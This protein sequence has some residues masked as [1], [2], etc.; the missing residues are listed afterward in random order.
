MKL[1]GKIYRLIYINYILAKNGLDE[2]ILAMRWFA[3]I[4]FLSYL[5]PWYWLRNRKKSRAERLR[6]TLESLGPIFVKFGQ[7]LSTRR[8]LLPEDI[9]NE[10][11]KLQ[12]KVPPFSG[13]KKIIE[14]TLEKPI[15]TL[16]VNFDEHALASASIAQ[17]HTAQLLDGQDV[18]IKVKRP[19]IEKIIKRDIDLL[20]SFAR[21][22]QH[23]TTFGKRI[24]A[25]DIISEFEQTILSELDLLRE[26]ANASILKRNFKDSKQLYIPE[27]HW[28]YCRENIMVMERI[29][30]IPISDINTL[31]AQNF[32]LEQL[33]KNGVEI[34]FTQVF[35]DCF[36]HGDMH[37]GNIFVH[38]SNK[39]NPQY[40]A[41]DFGIVG[42]L[43][44]TDQRYLAENMLAF[45]KRD[46]RRVAE[47]HLE[48]GWIPANTRVQEFESAIST[49][50]E[51]IFQKP[52][53]E[54]SFGQ[55]LMRLFQTGK[56]FH[57]EIQPQL[58][59]LQKTL[60]H[61]EGLGR[62]LCPEL[63]LWTSAEPILE[64]WMREQLGPKSILK[65]VKKNLP[66][67]FEKMPEMPDLIYQYLKNAPAQTPSLAVVNKNNDQPTPSKFWQ[68]F[69]VATL[70]IALSLFIV[71]DLGWITKTY[72]LY[73]TAGVAILGFCT[74]SLNTLLKKIGQL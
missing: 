28:Q 46:Y 3:P 49:V 67:W 21:L 38:P 30:G 20:Y 7:M 54:I 37:P 51:P 4:S 15:S 9:V 48:S 40:I 14:K 72:L 55:L 10:L 42:T 62:E 57:M 71:V 70:V 11:A 74:L 18:V 69:G 1:F 23:Y 39:D 41:I 13:A 53:K 47:L 52:L 29:Y 61:I 33:A 63:D 35:R 59:L 12:D 66:H 5:N 56:R 58:L 43:T 60:I 8:D 17:V 24:R 26:A 31:K 6:I 25:K 27:I 34:F 44:E 16:F 22:L 2:I 73:I 45:F 32:N 50:C 36:F 65:K 68:G 19:N 64:K